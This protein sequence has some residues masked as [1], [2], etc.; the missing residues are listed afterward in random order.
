MRKTNRLFSWGFVV[1][2][3]C[4]LVF[5]PVGV[6]HATSPDLVIYQVYGGG[7]NSGATY[8]NDFVVLFNRGSTSASLSG[9]S[10][11]Y[12]SA[13]GNIGGTGLVLILPAT[14][15]ASGQYYLI[16]LASGGAVGA[17]LPTP[18]DATG[19]INMS[20]TNGKVALVNSTTGL[21][22]GQTTSPANPC[23]STKLALIIDLI[24]F[25]SATMYEGSPAPVMSNTTADSRAG[26]GCTDTDNNSADFT[27]GTPAPL[28]SAS[29][30]H[31][32]SGSS[33]PSGVG[34]ANPSTVVPG[35]STPL[36]TVAVTPGANPPSTGLAVACDLTA[37]GGLASQTFLDDGNPPDALAGDNTF[38]FQASIPGSTTLGV[39]TLPC[40]ITDAQARTGNTS[41]GLTA[42]PALA[43]SKTAIAMVDI[44]QVFTYTLS[45][46]NNLDVAV[47]NL[48]ITDSLPLSA[49]S[50]GFRW[51]RTT[52]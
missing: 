44:N 52:R 42:A 50:I 18:V 33:N 23:D 37:I 38:T 11:Q 14:T 36:L 24:G 12:G 1:I 3:L 17:P 15:I 25:G 51:R 48:V 43:S 16:Q 28:N 10:I 29:S 21:G 20:A 19:S 31:Y 9:K 41:I 6:A 26:S 8:T 2:Y 22:C 5:S 47:T 39:K 49:P 34:T 30:A 4:G 45:M 13:A 7:G 32:C 27:A 35:Y 40:T 46:K